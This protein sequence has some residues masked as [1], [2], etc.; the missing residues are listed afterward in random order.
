ML[1]KTTQLEL[2]RRVT[3]YYLAFALSAIVWLTFGLVLVMVV[4]LRIGQ[5]E[6]SVWMTVCTA[7]KYAPAAV[8][9]PMLVVSLGAVVLKSTV[10]PV[11]QI[12]SQLFKIAIAPSIGDSDLRALQ[13][14]HPVEIG[15]N[16]V[17]ELR[18][19][20]TNHGGLDSRIDQGLEAFRQ[21]KAETILNSLSDGVAV[22]DPD[23]RVTFANQA[24]VALVGKEANTIPGSAMEECL[25]LSLAGERAEAF[26]N[27][28]LRERTVVAE[29]GRSGDMV[30][31]VL[32]VAR[33]PLRSSDGT[34]NTGHLWCIRDI[35][36][37][38]LA[39]QMRNQ[40]VYSA[41]HELR[42]PLANIK[43]YAETLALCDSLDVEK[44]KEFC[45]TINAEAHR[46][47]RFIDDL[48]SISRMEAGAMA[49]DRQETDL[50]R[51]FQETIRN[52]QPQM[53]QKKITFQAHL[54]E[55]LPKL[56]LDKDKFTV[57]LIN[58]LGNAAKY[59]PEG[60]RVVLQVE[61]REGQIQIEVAD[62]GFGISVQELSRI[63]DKF[64]RSADPRIQEQS[65]SG[66]GLSLAHEIVRLHGGKIA[67]HSEL[68]KGTKFIVSLPLS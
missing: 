49:L 66:L 38:K 36:Q 46:L 42:T 14:T 29:L 33:H 7:M 8:L 47:S 62:T 60:G 52:V 35:T 61:V 26:L 32:R 65:G 58:L 3:A 57:A 9:L 56:N 41:T 50:E 28:E 31:G 55:K 4:T 12:E 2:P 10:R 21:R 27:G 37:Q 13:P 18:N 63:F 59:T 51:L 20:R 43:A 1:G 48:L 5:P 45:N 25:E 53:I 17:I 23:G 54:P 30:K 44:Q 68:D 16:R 15:W 6:R 34:A 24:L 40:F 19:Q 11:T 64:F 39:D 67:V 22:T